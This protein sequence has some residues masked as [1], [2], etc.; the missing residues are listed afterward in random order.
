MRAAGSGERV[1]LQMCLDHQRFMVC[2]QHLGPCS[3]SF[4]AGRQEH[5]LPAQGTLSPHT[6]RE[7]QSETPGKLCK[8][9]VTD[10]FY[11]AREQVKKE[12]SVRKQ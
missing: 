2:G 7:G 10:L 8:R 5:L 9:K 1:F 4:S 3:V 6:A 11:V 12:W